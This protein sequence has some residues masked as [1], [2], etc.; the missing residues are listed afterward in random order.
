MTKKK[1]TSSTATKKLKLRKQ[2]LKDLDTRS[3]KK[4]KGG[5]LVAARTGICAFKPPPA[6]GSCACNDTYGCLL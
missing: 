6:T 4:I 2:T 5:T 3:G 1:A